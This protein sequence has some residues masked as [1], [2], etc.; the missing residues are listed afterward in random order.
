MEE[1]KPYASYAVLHELNRREFRKRLNLFPAEQRHYLIL[2]TGII[3]AENARRVEETPAAVVRD[4]ED[5]VADLLDIVSP[6]KDEEFRE[7]LE[8]CLVETMK[9]E[10]KFCC[11]N[12]MNFDKCIDLEHLS[13]G[14][15]FR[16]RSAG[17]DS[18]ELKMAIA[19]QLD[20]AFQKT[21]YLESDSAQKLCVDFR[22][23]YTASSIG[24]VFNRYADI[25]AGLQNSFGIDY[26]KIQLVMISLNMDF[27]EKSKE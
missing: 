10:L 20:H 24:D 15:L 6:G 9:D 5:F 21:P 1:I 2:A 25:A 11:S 13:V 22:H 3:G 27:Y 18:D 14:H 4:G 17:Q 26:H 12:C 8:T 16:E 19:R 7:V 23:Q